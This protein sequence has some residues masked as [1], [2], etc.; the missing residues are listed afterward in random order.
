LA[1]GVFAPLGF[2]KPDGFRLA[3]VPPFVLFPGGGKPG[4]E[5]Q[6]DQ[7]SADDGVY[8]HGRKINR[9]PP[10]DK[11][12]AVK[13]DELRSLQNQRSGVAAARQNAANPGN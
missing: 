11:P 3:H 2:H 7:L 13:F 10:F 12:C 8:I 4:R 6:P 5:L 9:V 1:Q